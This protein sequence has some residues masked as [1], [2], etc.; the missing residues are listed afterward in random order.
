MHD[1]QKP[2]EVKEKSLGLPIF[3]HSDLRELRLPAPEFRVLGHVASRGKCYETVESMAHY[4]R[5]KPKTV[6][7]CLQSLTKNWLI[8]AQQRSGQTTVYEIN[9]RDC[10]KVNPSQNGPRVE[11]TAPELS[12]ATPPQAGQG[13]PS[14]L[15]PGVVSPPS[16]FGPGH[17]S[18]LGP[19]DPSPLGPVKGHP[20]KAIPD[21]ALSCNALSQS[22]AEDDEICRR[23]D[24]IIPDWRQN[25]PAY[26]RRMNRDRRKF[27]RVFN[28]TQNAVNEQ[29]I[30]KS[31]GAYFM[32][33]WKRFSGSK[34][35]L[36]AAEPANG[37]RINRSVETKPA[38]PKPTRRDSRIK[39]LA[40]KSEEEKAAE[41]A[42]FAKLR[43]SI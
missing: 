43:Q 9:P 36:P 26:E 24:Y 31:A 34:N 14:P 25:R 39:P 29:K 33:T 40:D 37:K 41:R 15:G 12:H 32:D 23:L 5:L 30:K 16:P 22:T 28:D 17:P 6:R 3:V 10:W 21:K 7:R 1:S 19:G 2:E 13:Y 20:I 4:C 35:D 18:P 27:E 38:I 42:G 8:C 11:L